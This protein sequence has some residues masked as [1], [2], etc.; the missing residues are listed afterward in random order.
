MIVTVLQTW[1]ENLPIRMQST[2]VLGLRGPDTHNVPH[3][4][5][6]IRW[7]RGVTFKP[8][9]PA[10]ISEFMHHDPATLEEKGP[11]AKELEFCTFH[12]F[13]HI[14]QSLKVIAWR[15]PHG[16]TAHMAYCRMVQMCD[17]LHLPIESNDSFNERLKQIDWP[18][19]PDTLEDALH[20]LENKNLV[21]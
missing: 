18:G 3:L 15:H 12:C 14:L 20:I 9:N 21:G 13:T 6:I 17:L 11:A 16:H 8:G 1:V 4:K 10:N 19:Q 5:S 2:L 7:M